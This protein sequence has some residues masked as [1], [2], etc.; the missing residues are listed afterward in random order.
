M[1]P[2]LDAHTQ[3]CAIFG[4]P[5]GH[6]LSPAIH[7]AAF[8]ALGLNMVY[9][10]HDVAPANLPAA[11]AGVRALG[12]RGLSITIPHKVAALSLVDEV[13][14]TARR[15][16]CINT[17]VNDGGVLKGRNTDGL[18]AIGALR[19]ANVDLQQSSVV[20]LGSGGAARAIAVTLV[21]EATPRKLTLLGIDEP[22]L[23]ALAGTLREIRKTDIATGRLNRSGIET[24][25]AGANLVLHTTPIGM[26]PN[27]EESVV[28][29][30]LLHPGLTVFDA[31]YT[32]RRTRLLR[33]A[34]EHGCRTIE[35]LEMFLG[36]ALV[37]FQLWTG[38]EP[39]KQVMRAVIEDRLGKA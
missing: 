30:E 4:H 13:D 6:S 8:D 15:I 33:D 19:S 35:G 22:E 11:M 37:Q 32:P 21:A 27:S 38:R 18:G 5:V 12:Y 17:V 39:P 34:A 16:G 2:V 23:M 10:A 3:T 26:H 7:N 25:F 31:V 28:P 1:A 36:Q 24:A 14:E 9:V 20:V 29:T